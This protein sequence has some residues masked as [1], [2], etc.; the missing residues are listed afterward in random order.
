MEE[1]KEFDKKIDLEQNNL[2]D[3]ESKKNDLNKKIADLNNELKSCEPSNNSSIKKSLKVQKEKL[4]DLEIQISNKNEDIN[5]LIEEKNTII[6]KCLMNL[7]AK[8]KKDYQ[9]VNEDHDK[10]VDLYTQAREDKHVIE[11]N[12]MNLKFLVY[13]NYNVRLV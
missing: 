2:T 3:M 13:K 8:I 7:H 12:I 1:I 11:R 9:K 6:K 5:S 10:Y 4:D